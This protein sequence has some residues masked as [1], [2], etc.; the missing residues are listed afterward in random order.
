MAGSLERLKERTTLIWNLRGCGS[1]LGWDQLVKMPPGGAEARAGQKAALSR[2]AHEALISPDFL[3]DL[4]AAEQEVAELPADSDDACLVRAS[5]RAYDRSARVPG[6]LVAEL[7]STTARAYEAWVEA[8]HRSDF[9]FFLPHF[10]KVLAL[11]R[12]VVEHRGYPEHPYDAFLDD[13][14]PGIRASQVRTLFGGLKPGLV[15]LARKVRESGPELSHNPLDQSFP[16][17][18]Q[19]QFAARL[20]RSVGY[21][22]TRGRM[23]VSEHPF[24]SASSSRDV[25]ITTRYSEDNMVSALFGAIHESGHAVYEQGSPSGFD[26]TPLKGGCSLGFH[27]SQSRL[28]ENY[29]GR[30]RAYWKFHYPALVALFPIQLQGY[31]LDDFYRAINQVRPTLIRVEADEVTYSLHVMLRFEIEYH[32]VD[33]TLAPEDVPHEWN[34]RMEEY[35]GVRPPDDAQGCLQDVHWSEALIGYFPTY[36]LGT[37][38]A[39]QIWETVREGIPGVDEQ[40][41]RGDTSVLLGWLQDRIYRHASK[42]LP[43]ELVERCTGKPLHYRAFLTYLEDKYGDLY[44]L[45]RQR[46]AHV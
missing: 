12:E 32:M 40:L 35:L 27:E 21:D 15:E 11:S 30:S 1:L 4:E 9:P 7:A 38:L 29:V 26:G 13:Y 17:D 20:A 6:R 42:F 46:V 43:D 5:R 24:C 41:S 31:S 34:Q 8:R 16:V 23:D 14:E 22:F 37:M 10:K 44:G 45:G 25:R 3:R 28:W 18:L 2:V 33:G 39:A 19:R 36:C